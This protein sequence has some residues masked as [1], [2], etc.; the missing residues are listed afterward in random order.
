MPQ[1][2]APQPPSPAGTYEGGWEEEEDARQ[3]CGHPTGQ[4]EGATAAA[5]DCGWG[6]AQP[7][8]LLFS[9]GC[10]SPNV[11]FQAQEPPFSSSRK[12]LRNL[13]FF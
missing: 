12:Q 6:S 11:L 13:C 3:D 10:V 7:L 1:V 8:L 5:R 2:P 4:A 9:F